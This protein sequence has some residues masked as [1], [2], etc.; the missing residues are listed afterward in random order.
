MIEEDERPDGLAGARGQHAADGE[1]A[2]VAD[3]GREEERCGGHFISDGG[4]AAVR[5]ALL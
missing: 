4:D 2:E 3:M 1:A 5:G